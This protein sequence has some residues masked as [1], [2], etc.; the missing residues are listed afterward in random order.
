MG[1]YIFLSVLTM[2]RLFVTCT[3]NSKD[4]GAR[5]EAENEAG[6]FGSA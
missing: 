6:A 1:R 4:Q 2:N 5:I 3:R